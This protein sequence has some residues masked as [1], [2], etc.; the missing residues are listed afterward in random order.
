MYPKVFTDFAEAQDHYGPISVLPT[1]IYF[2]GMQPGE[3]I[4]VEIEKGKTLVILRAGDRR[5]RRGRVRSASSSNSTASRASSRCRTARRPRK[6][7]ARRKAE[8]GNAD[9]VA[10]PMPGV[11]STVAVDGRA[12]RSRPATCCCRSRR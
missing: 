4:A 1:P 3:E 10:A 11:V 6:V 2:Y 7:A 12:G 9:H 5:D 8:D